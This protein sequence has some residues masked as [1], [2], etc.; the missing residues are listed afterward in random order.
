MT[1]RTSR[2]L[3]LIAAISVVA[4]LVCSV[5]CSAEV[6]QATGGIAGLNN[7]TLLGGDGTGQA[8]IT[9]SGTTLG[10]V[11]QTRDA[12]GTVLPNGSDVAAAQTIYFVL[13]VDNTTSFPAADLRITDLI[14]ETQFTYVASSLEQTSVPTGSNDAAI[15]AGTWTALTDG[16]GGPDDDASATDTGGPAGLDRVTVGAVTGQANNSVSVPGSTLRA[17]RLQV[18]VN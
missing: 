2:S 1:T 8:A 18:T 5:P 11:K 3:V 10:L 9:L 15:W 14:D 4:S 16:V 7:A 12:G 6:N 17:Y 13:Y